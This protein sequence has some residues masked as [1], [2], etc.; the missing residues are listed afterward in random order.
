MVNFT[1]LHSKDFAFVATWGDVASKDNGP[2]RN[3]ALSNLMAQMMHLPSKGLAQAEIT[4]KSVI[5]FRLLHI[6]I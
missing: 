5:L 6:T 1:Y 3:R 2:P 4:K